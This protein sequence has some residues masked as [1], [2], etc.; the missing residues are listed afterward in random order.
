[1]VEKDQQENPQSQERLRKWTNTHQLIKLNSIWW[2]L[3][4]GVDR[5][6][7]AGDNNLKRGVISCYHDAPE[8]GHPGISNTYEIM[9]RDFWWPNMKLDIEQFVKGC[10]A[11]QANKA[12]TR[13]LKPAMIPITPE[14]TLP[15]QTVAMDF[16]TKLPKSGKY[17]TILT[18]TDHDCSKAAIFLPCQETITAEGVATLYLRYV[19]PRF[20]LPKKVISDRDTRF[21]SKY[22]K[23]T[24]S[25]DEDTPE[26]INGVP[27]KDGWT[28]RTHKPMVR[29]VP[30]VLVRRTTGRLAQ[31]VANGRIRAQLVAKRNDE[32]S[33]L[34]SDNGV[35]STG[36]MED[37]TKPSAERIGK[38]G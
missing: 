25:S 7:V 20:G 2:K 34:R 5:I 19:F 15:F 24:V 16:I 12:N 9:K 14:H 18:I 17:D 28:V 31:V 32:T 26:H 37:E 38:T 27:S 30:Q 29:T 1:L 11:C 22:A 6:V 21:T 36:R 4:D 35:P 3:E 10:V 23:G 33:P 13:P 8:R